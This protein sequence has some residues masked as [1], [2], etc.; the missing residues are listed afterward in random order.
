MS[1]RH[2]RSLLGLSLVLAIASLGCGNSGTGGAPAAPASTPPATPSTP[3]APPSTPAAPPA[4]P[5]APPAIKPPNKAI[6]VTL[7]DSGG[8]A[9]EDV[10]C[11]AM[12][13]DKMPMLKPDT[14][15]IWT[16]TANGSGCMSGYNASKLAMK[17]GKNSKLFVDKNALKTCVPQ[18]TY[19]CAITATIVD[20][21][22]VKAGSKHPYGITLDD[23]DLGDPEIDIDN[24]NGAPG[25][26]TPPPTGD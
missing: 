4:T 6:A 11:L 19:V 3:A 24:G 9:G 7:N 5:G 18:S 14:T 22:M 8:T 20:K 15:I 23:D 2:Y 13:S 10:P 1:R 25:P 16:V 17:F 21:T 12:V 26:G